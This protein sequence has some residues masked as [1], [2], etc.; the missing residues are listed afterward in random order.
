[1]MAQSMLLQLL[2]MFFFVSS[3]LF[4][5]LRMGYDYIVIPTDKPNKAALGIVAKWTIERGNVHF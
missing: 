4:T 1:M 2:S 5:A 3:A